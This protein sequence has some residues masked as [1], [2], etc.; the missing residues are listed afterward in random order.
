MKRPKRPTYTQAAWLR[1]IALSPL[2]VTR[3]PEAGAS[4]SLTNGAV[5][6]E[7]TAKVL[8]R[9]GW[10]ASECDGLFPDPAEAQ[11]YRVRTPT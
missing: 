5:V 1:R 7:P 3:T 10:V 9:N 8:I 2:M 11:T 4:Y 6:P